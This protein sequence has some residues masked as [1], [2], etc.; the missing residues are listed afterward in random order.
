VFEVTSRD[1]RGYVRHSDQTAV[2]AFAMSEWHCLHKAVS[3]PLT[4]QPRGDRH[5]SGSRQNADYV[6]DRLLEMTVKL[7]AFPE[8]EVPAKE[9]RSLGIQEYRQLLFK[10]HSGIYRVVGEQAI[11]YDIADGKRDMQILL[12][13]RLLGA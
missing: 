5:A 7:M 11:I 9:L 4:F 12:P 1:G 2:R 10:P 3:A 8:R 6:L 13:R